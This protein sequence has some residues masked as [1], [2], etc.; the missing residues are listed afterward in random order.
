MQYFVQNNAEIFKN[1][2]EKKG[3]IHYLD[4]LYAF[5]LFFIEWRDFSLF[6]PY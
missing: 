3:T 2:K 4:F 6:L 1:L 5:S